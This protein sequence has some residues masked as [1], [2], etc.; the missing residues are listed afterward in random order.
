MNNNNVQTRNRIIETVMNLD[1][2]FCPMILK[3][4]K[5]EF[6]AFGKSLVFYRGQPDK[7]NLKKT[8]MSFDEVL[9]AGWE[10]VLYS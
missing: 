9:D 1:N 6:G 5:T 7:N 10:I 2:N 8:E 3:G 4:P